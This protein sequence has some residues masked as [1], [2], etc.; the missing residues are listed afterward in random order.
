MI[1]WSF[2]RSNERWIPRVSSFFA[3]D[4]LPGIA[5]PEFIGGCGSPDMYETSRKSRGYLSYQ[6]VQK[7]FPSIVWYMYVYNIY[8]YIYAWSPTDLYFWRSKVS[9]YPT[10]TRVIWV[11]GIFMSILLINKSY[12]KDSPWFICSFLRSFEFEIWCQA[13]AQ[14]I[15]PEKHL[16]FQRSFKQTMVDLEQQTA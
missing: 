7:F 11:P 1:F 16:E 9:N 15:L 8:I 14:H 6:L 10:K 4:E 12:V 2:G 5:G 3:A 13:L